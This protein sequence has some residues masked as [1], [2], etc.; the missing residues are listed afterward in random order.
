M[1]EHET[2]SEADIL[3]ALE[4]IEKNREWVSKNYQMLQSKYQGKVFAIKDKQIVAVSGNITELVDEVR[5]KGQDSATLLL[6]SIPP[7]GVVYIL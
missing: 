7:K 6:E 1:S 3:K 2:E 4:A 5:A